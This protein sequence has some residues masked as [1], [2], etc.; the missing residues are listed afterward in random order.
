M[1][2]VAR[3]PPRSVRRAKFNRW[4]SITARVLDAEGAPDVALD[5]HDTASDNA[6]AEG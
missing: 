2:E 5:C 6:G 1:S 4:F 3:M